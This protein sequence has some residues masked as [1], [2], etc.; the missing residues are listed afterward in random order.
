MERQRSQIEPQRSAGGAK[1]SASGPKLRAGGALMEPNG[2]PAEPNR[3]TLVNMERQSKTTIIDGLL[4][5]K[6]GLGAAG[7][8]EMSY[9]SSWTNEN[10]VL[11]RMDKPKFR[12]GTAGQVKMLSWSSWMSRNVVQEQLDR[13]KCRPGAAGLGQLQ[14]GKATKTTK[15]RT[16]EARIEHSYIDINIYIYM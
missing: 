7:Q 5:K 11:E 12:P 13:L 1:W 6:Q 14:A 3:A 4:I 16:S 15:S 2:A 8:V 10:V 9:W